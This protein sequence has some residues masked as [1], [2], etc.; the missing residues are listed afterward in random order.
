MFF[1]SFPDL[2]PFFERFR[3]FTLW[4]FF[5]PVLYFMMVSALIHEGSSGREKYFYSIV[6]NI[7][8]GSLT[9]GLYLL[10]WDEEKIILVMNN[11]TLGDGE[12]KKKNNILWFIFYKISSKYFSFL[13]VFIFFAI[14]FK[15]KKDI[16]VTPTR[17]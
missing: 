1:I 7:V 14:V 8:Y 2:W 15:L 6:F 5:F 3:A 16:S 10:T 12:S 11:S 4:N 17:L 13:S 9:T